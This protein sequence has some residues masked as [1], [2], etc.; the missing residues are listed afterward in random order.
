MDYA[1]RTHTMIYMRC[2]LQLPSLLY[3]SIDGTNQQVLLL[4]EIQHEYQLP[5]EPG[6]LPRWM[7]GA[8]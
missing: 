1:D 5:C 6:N 7:Q 8:T 3:D 4:Q 2:R